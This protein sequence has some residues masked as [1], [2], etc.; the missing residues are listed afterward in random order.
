MNEYVFDHMPMGEEGLKEIFSW[1]DNCVND[2]KEIAEKI[3]I[4]KSEDGKWD[5]PAV[6]VTNR[7]VPKE[8]K[9]VAIITLARH[10]QEKGARVVAPEIINYLVSN[11]AAET[12]EK[13]IVIVVPV[14]N[15]EG[16]V[17]DEFHSSAY[18]I[19]EHEQAIFANL[20]SQYVPDMMLDYHSLGMIEGARCDLGDMEV[21]IPGNTT[22]WGMD[23]QIYQSVAEM[24]TENAASEG[25]PYEIH[26]LEDLSTYYFGDA[27][28]GKMPYK[29][30]QEKV[31]LLHMQDHYEEYGFS[32]M[33]F[34]NYTNGPA[35]LRWHTF[36][37]GV[38][39]NH[40]SIGIEEGLAESGVVIAK[41]LLDIGNNKFS[42]QKNTG[43]PND[44]LLGDFRMSVRAAGNNAEE[45]RISR[46]KIWGQREKINVFKRRMEKDHGVTL[47]EL[48]YS[49][50]GPL[51][52]ELCFRMRQ[53][54]IKQVFLGDKEVE[55]DTFKDNCS[56]YVSIPVSIEKSGMA[57]LKI[58]HEPYRKTV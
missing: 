27:D 14:V 52:C 24:L 23:E 10:G 26:S 17:L 21:I 4:G 46:E 35:Y 31:F 53:D 57:E 19:T 3:V 45:R 34:N 40:W 7:D 49:G 33:K 51:K 32:D 44:I 13:Q 12:R 28:S 37:M 43:Y 11:A 16:V 6:V 55:F 22:K 42:W 58:I 18:G 48:G 56:T 20:C 47:A 30:L 50:E 2:N 1:I 38:E 39:T 9:Q 8:D 54:K 25:W 41:G 5:I 36:V 29:Y 15:P